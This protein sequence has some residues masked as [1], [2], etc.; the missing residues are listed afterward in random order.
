MVMLKRFTAHSKLKFAT[1]TAHFVNDVSTSLLPA[2]IVVLRDEFDLSHTLQ[3]ALITSSV[4]LMTALQA[5]VGYVADRRNR[6]HLL[7]LG[8]TTLGIGTILVA[9]ATNYFQLLLFAFLL[10][11]G[12]SFFHPIGYSLLSDAFEFENRGKALGVGSAS[13]D[14]AVPVAFAMSGIL[15]L[16]VGWRPI[17]IFWGLI[18]I[19]VAATLPLIITEPEKACAHTN[20]TGNSTAKTIWTLIP[21]VIVMGLAAASFRIASTFTT[22]YL[23]TLGLRIE[24]ANFVFALMMCVGVVGSLAGGNS[25]EKLGEK[26]TVIIGM[27]MLSVLSMVSICVN[28]VYFTPAIIVLIGFFLL[29]VWPPFYSFIAKATNL[30]ARAFMYGLIFAIAWSFGSLWP[31]MSGVCA[32]IFGIQV[33]YIL[34]GG[35]SL[36]GALTAHITFKK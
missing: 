11:I 30:G 17:F 31:F 23:R 24:S 35:L 15:I 18:A 16:S 5:V 36:F 6:V 25:I 29:G 2:V 26:R 3:G 34:I 14:I 7:S 9:F 20:K 13:G 28:N 33:T 8:L 22:T 32:D 12:G 4:F 27:V 1:S 21:V 10:G 19:I